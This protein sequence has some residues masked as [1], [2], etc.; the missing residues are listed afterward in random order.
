MPPQRGHQHLHRVLHQLERL[1]PRGR[2]PD[3]RSAEHDVAEGGGRGLTVILTDFHQRADEIFDM[4][5]RTTTLRHE[6][7]VMHIIGRRER[8]LDWHGAT[9][10]EDIETG[11][12]I[13][14]DADRPRA[15]Y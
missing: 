13:E 14:L 2:W 1:E 9:T 6:T 11:A 7:L 10:F 4:V 12:H 8:D 5:R 3:W 15:S